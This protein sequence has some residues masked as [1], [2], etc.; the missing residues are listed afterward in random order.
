MT[1][2]SPAMITRT[3]A[4]DI[5]HVGKD[6]RETLERMLKNEVDGKCIVEGFVKPESVSI[7]TFSNGDV[8][9]ANVMFEVVYEC[10]VCSPVEGMVFPCIVKNNTK[11]GIRAETADSPSPV[12]VFLSRDHHY[13]MEGFSQIEPGEEISIRVIGQRFELN[14]PQV[15]VI[16]ELVKK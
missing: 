2:Y 11:A 5:V 6:V 8:R 4:V 12:V 9:G 14:D 7:R 16:A 3:M 1:I 15:S 10:E 13:H